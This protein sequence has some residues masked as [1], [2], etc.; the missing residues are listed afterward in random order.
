MYSYPKWLFLGHHPLNRQVTWNTPDLRDEGLTP[1]PWCRVFAASQRPITAQLITDFGGPGWLA[2]FAG[3]AA[4]YLFR[5]GTGDEP[6]R[7]IGRT[8]PVAA[9]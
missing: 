3:R 6:S 2:T 8:D 4:V 5:Q 1:V 9:H 7:P